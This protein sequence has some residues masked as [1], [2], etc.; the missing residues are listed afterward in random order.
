MLDPLIAFVGK[1][2]CGSYTFTDFAEAWPLVFPDVPINLDMPV[3]EF[4]NLML[5]RLKEIGLL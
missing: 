4:T 3:S 1:L 5:E 2:H